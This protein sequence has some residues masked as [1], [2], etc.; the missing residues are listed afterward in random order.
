LPSVV[1]VMRTVLRR[2]GIEHDVTVADPGLRVRVLE[3]GD[4]PAGIAALIAE[5]LITNGPGE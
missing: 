2:G 5:F 3:V 1:P 4:G